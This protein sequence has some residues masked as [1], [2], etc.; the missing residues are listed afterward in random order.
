MRISLF[1]AAFLIAAAPS[2]QSLQDAP[3]ALDRAQIEAHAAEQAPAAQ[4]APALTPDLS[5]WMAPAS[6][7]ADA[8]AGDD[9]QELPDDASSSQDFVY[10]GSLAAT[11][12]ILVAFGMFFF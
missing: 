3:E 10:Y 6:D 12:G 2:A 11:A 9:F 5:E 4:P 8:L 7:A 1:L